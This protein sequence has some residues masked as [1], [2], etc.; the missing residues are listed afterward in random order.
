MSAP[1]IFNTAMSFVG[2]VVWLLW[3]IKNKGRRGY[4]VL[5]LVYLFNVLAFYLFYYFH[6]VDIP[7]INTWSNVIR[8]YSIILIVAIPIL[9]L[10]YGGAR[11]NL[12][13]PR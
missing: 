10:Y 8:A 11:W 9:L 5:P 13:R 6:I 7:T 1:A 12:T 3:A 4:A 2:I